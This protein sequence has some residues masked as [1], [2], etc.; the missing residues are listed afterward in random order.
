MRR[1]I[2]AY[3]KEFFCL[4]PRTQAA[5][6]RD[7]NKKWCFEYLEFKTLS[8]IYRHRREKGDRYMQDAKREYFKKFGEDLFTDDEGWQ[9]GFKVWG[10]YTHKSEDRFLS[11]PLEC[12]FYAKL[13]FSEEGK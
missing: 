1:I 6:L 8:I 13:A 12:Y 5:F 10:Q 9:A 4:D 11:Y 7:Y 2:R 3:I